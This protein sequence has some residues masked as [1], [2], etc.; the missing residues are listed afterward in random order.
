MGQK[1]NSAG[2]EAQPTHPPVAPPPTRE[3]TRWW[4]SADSSS[5]SRKMAKPRASP[6]ARRGPIRSLA[7]CISLAPEPPAPS[8]PPLPRRHQVA[9]PRNLN[10]PLREPLLMTDRE[11][12][13]IY[14]LLFLALG[15]SLR[16]KLIKSTESQ[17]IK[18]QGLMVY[19]STG[20][21]LMVLGH[22]YFADQLPPNAENFINVNRIKTQKFST[23]S[24]QFGTGIAQNVMSRNYYLTDGKNSFRIDGQYTVP[25]WQWLMRN[26]SRAATPPPGQRGQA[27]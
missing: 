19:D 1:S 3:T 13:I 26:T 24:A 7:G 8:R 17:R 9:H 23:D 14:P 10:P 5:T 20:Q 12:W 15:A 18:C 6:C 16:D 27:P 25:I 21:P 22:E 11:R 2:W 4:K